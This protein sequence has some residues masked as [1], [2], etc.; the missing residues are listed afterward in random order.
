MQL[1]ANTMLNCIPEGPRAFGARVEAA[2]G[3]DGPGLPRFCPG[4]ASPP[5][6]VEGSAQGSYIVSLRWRGTAPVGAILLPP[7]AAYTHRPSGRYRIP[8]P[9]AAAPCIGQPTKGRPFYVQAKGLLRLTRRPYAGS[10]HSEHNPSIQPA[11][12]AAPPLALGN[13][14][15][16]AIAAESGHTVPLSHCPTISPAHYF[17]SIFTY[18]SPVSSISAF[19]P[20]RSVKKRIWVSLFPGRQRNLITTLSVKARSLTI[21][22]VSLM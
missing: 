9:E 19:P 4:P 22:S 20:V 18:S 3:P 11:A 1:Y 12:A 7:L 6:Q 21:M 10:P 2:G 8:R 14:V 13:M 17:L 16:P 15:Q 5:G